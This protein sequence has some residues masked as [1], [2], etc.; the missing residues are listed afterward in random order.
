M[1]KSYQYTLITLLLA[2]AFV[3]G[4]M[5]GMD[6]ILRVREKKI[7]SA[8]GTAAMASPVRAWQQWEAQVAEETEKQAGSDGYVL[9]F[10]QIEEVIRSRTNYDEEVIHEPVR[11]QI[12]IE[13]AIE[14]GKKWIAEMAVEERN[15][16]K[17]DEEIYFVNAILGIRKYKEVSNVQMEPYYSF[18]TVRFSSESMG[19]V[20]YINAIT[21]KVWNAEISLYDTMLDEV[22]YENL[23]CFSELA[24]F[25]VSD[26]PSVEMKDGRKWANLA[27]ED[28]LLYT[29]MECYE[30]NVDKNGI[31]DYSETGK[32]RDKYLVITYDLLLKEN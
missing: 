18:W 10:R 4:S 1:N 29:Q 6:F 13:K 27:I 11:G 14:A 3:I 20:L 28:S 7:L 12:S 19:I 2:A 32:F 23:S 24:G 15:G 9:N 5:A 30:V 22:P 17:L 21:G 8:S 25:K 16:R 31:V 26:E